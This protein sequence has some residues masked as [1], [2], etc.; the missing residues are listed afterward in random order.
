MNKQLVTYTNYF[1]KP[2]IQMDYLNIDILIINQLNNYNFS[3]NIIYVFK[4]YLK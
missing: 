3:K 2:I 1:M 4:I